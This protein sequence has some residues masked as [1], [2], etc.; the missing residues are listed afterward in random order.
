MATQVVDSRCFGFGFGF[1]SFIC[2]YC[3]TRVRKNLAEELV[4]T[5]AGLAGHFETELMHSWGC[6]LK[7]RRVRKENRIWSFLC[8]AKLAKKQAGKLSEKLAEKLIDHFEH[9]FASP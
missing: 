1:F 6:A 5:E 3:D 2:V 7:E 9:P 8:I 4:G